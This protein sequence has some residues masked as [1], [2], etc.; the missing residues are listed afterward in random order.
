MTK[1]PLNL[2]V[3]KLIHYFQHELYSEQGKKKYLA[4]MGHLA[5]KC[6]ELSSSLHLFYSDYWIR[7]PMNL[8]Q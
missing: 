4:D 6:R 8:K 3:L 2:Y 7:I 1:V 5:L